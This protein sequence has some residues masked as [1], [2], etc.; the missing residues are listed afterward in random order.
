MTDGRLRT[1]IAAGTVAVVCGWLAGCIVFAGWLGLPD[2]FPQGF[3][4]AVV[5]PVAA[6]ISRIFWI[7]LR[8]DV[9]A[10]FLEWMNE[11]RNDG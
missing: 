6:V 7:H 4:I 9:A 10:D 11:R 2:P 1:C 5:V 8:D 3:V